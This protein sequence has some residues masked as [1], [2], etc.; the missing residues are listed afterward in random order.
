MCVHG[1]THPPGSLLSRCDQLAF[2]SPAF[3][4]EPLSLLQVHCKPAFLWMAPLTTLLSAVMASC[5]HCLSPALYPHAYHSL[6]Y[7]FTFG[8]CDRNVSSAR[9]GVLVFSLSISGSSGMFV[10]WKDEET[11]LISTFQ[12]FYSQRS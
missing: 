9:T 10:R 7:L 11:G 6:V 12:Y 4:D 1:G 5:L 8:S 3:D 2:T